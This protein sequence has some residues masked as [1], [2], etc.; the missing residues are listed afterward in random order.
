MDITAVYNDFV[1]VA[2][3]AMDSTCEAAKQAANYYPRTLAISA[4]TSVVFTILFPTTLSVITLALTC[5]VIYPL[6]DRILAAIQIHNQCDINEF[7]SSNEDKKIAIVAINTYLA[8]Y[9]FT[10]LC[11]SAFHSFHSIF[12]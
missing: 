11:S 1:D 9:R 8:T 3:K 2:A 6:K 5:C 12:S 10:E 4:I 7:T